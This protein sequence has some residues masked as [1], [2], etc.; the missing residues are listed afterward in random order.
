[1]KPQLLHRHFVV[2]T[3]DKHL[4]AG[5][6]ALLRVGRGPPRGVRSRPPPVAHDH[7]L[8][9]E[10]GQDGGND[11]AERGGEAAAERRR[12]C[13]WEDEDGQ[14]GGDSVLKAVHAADDDGTLLVVAGADLVGPCVAATVSGGTSLTRVGD[15][16]PTILPSSTEC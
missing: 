8:D 4:L 7:V 9:G 11:E 6:R 15:G 14:P 10:D 1:M 5:Q 3:G 13:L 12:R 16:G 2:L